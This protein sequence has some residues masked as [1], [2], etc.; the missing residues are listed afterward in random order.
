MME[1]K[2]GRIT[3]TEERNRDNRSPASNNE[4]AND[5]AAGGG[6]WEIRRMVG[7]LAD[8]WPH[9]DEHGSMNRRQWSAC[10]S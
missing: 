6:S 2:G 1:M 3:E 10:S 4:T 7:R 9:A 8:R 5:D